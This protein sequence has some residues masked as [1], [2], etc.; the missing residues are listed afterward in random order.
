MNV[1]TIRY[2]DNRLATKYYGILRNL[3]ASNTHAWDTRR[4]FFFVHDDWTKFSFILFKSN[5]YNCTNGTWSITSQMKILIKFTEFVYMTPLILIV[6]CSYSDYKSHYDSIVIISRILKIF[7]L[8][9]FRTHWIIQ[10]STRRHHKDCSPCLV[11]HTYTHNAHSC[12]CG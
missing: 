12:L 4:V 7:F 6:L 1:L 10:F 2:S 9:S 5:G 8:S 3:I 11:L